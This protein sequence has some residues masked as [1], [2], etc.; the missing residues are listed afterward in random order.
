MALVYDTTGKAKS[1]QVTIPLVGGG[2]GKSGPT[3]QVFNDSGSFMGDLF[4]FST[5]QGAIAGWKTGTAATVRVDNS[6]SEAIYKGLAIV[7]MTGGKALVAPDFHNGKI[8]VFSQGYAAVPGNDK[9]RTRASRSYALQRRVLRRQRVR[10]VCEAG[11]RQ[12]DDVRAP[13][14]ATSICSSPMAR[15]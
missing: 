13:V 7:S 5:E 6:G 1:V 8:D 15:A 9:F 14:S 4:I 3:G 12:R 10:H 2:T 11:C